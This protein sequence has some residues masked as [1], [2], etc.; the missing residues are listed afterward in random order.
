MSAE[1]G[2]RVVHRYSHS[3]GNNPKTKFADWVAYVVDAKSM[4]GTRD[5]RWKPDPK[6][7]A[8]ATLE[9]ADY[10]GA[11]A[12]HGYDRGHQGPLASLTGWPE[13][14]KTNYLSNITP[15][16]GALNQGPWK[17]LEDAVRVAVRAG[18]APRAIV[19]TGPLYEREM[20]ALP[21]SDEAHTVPSGYWKLV[22]LDM[23]GGRAPAGFVMDQAMAR[24]DDRCAVERWS[25][26]AGIEAR[27][28]TKLLADVP[29]VER[30]AMIERS[31]VARLALGC[32][33]GPELASAAN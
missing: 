11:N 16:K 5:R 19:F 23:A 14:E 18:K 1:T 9:P 12:A 28:G 26:I 2:G 32:V 24:K 8:E 27:A 25:T 7:P 15:Q 3:L 30:E 10:K 33:L 6:L 21:K 17:K 22:V 20:P 4:D 29:A 31:I 13:W